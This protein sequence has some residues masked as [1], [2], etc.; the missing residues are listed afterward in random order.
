MVKKKVNFLEKI[1]MKDTIL[2]GAII[3]L[4]YNLSSSY[5]LSMELFKPYDNQDFIKDSPSW[6]FSTTRLMSFT[7]SFFAY[8]CLISL[9]N[10]LKNHKKKAFKVWG[11]LTLILIFGIIISEFN[12]ARYETYQFYFMGFLSKIFV[13]SGVL[14]FISYLIYGMYR[15]TKKIIKK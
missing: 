13:L 15:L 6:I 10:F 1:N 8:V 3:F 4:I 11:I 5:N 2:Y 7:F 12:D 14:S 9:I